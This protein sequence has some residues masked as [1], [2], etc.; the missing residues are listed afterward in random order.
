[1]K[2]YPQMISLFDISLR[3]NG[4]P[5]KKAKAELDEIVNLSEEEYV[6]FLQNKKKEIVDFHLKNN[7]FYK[8][9][10]RKQTES[11]KTS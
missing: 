6:L 9:L 11:T 10:V 4:F 3:L 2:I 5:V 7:P 1:M 8:N